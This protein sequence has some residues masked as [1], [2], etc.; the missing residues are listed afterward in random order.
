MDIYFILLYKKRKIYEVSSIEIIE[1]SVENSICVNH[2][3][4]DKDMNSVI[5]NASI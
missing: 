2:M 5:S 3:S 1:V 4:A